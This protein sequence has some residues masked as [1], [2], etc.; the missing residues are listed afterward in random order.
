MRDPTAK[1][2]AALRDAA[3]AEQ[4]HL[5]ILQLDVDDPPAAERAV[6]VVQQQAGQVDAL[7]NNAGIGGGG[8][9][10]ETPE[11]ILRA[12]FEQALATPRK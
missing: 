3:T 7:I 8:A 4:L 9:I 5:E 2:A 11:A 10:E 6:R 12:V 1:G